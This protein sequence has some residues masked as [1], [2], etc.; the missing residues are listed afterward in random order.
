MESPRR[1]HV[2][3][4]RHVRKVPIASL[5]AA[6]C[7]MLLLRET[8]RTAPDLSELIDRLLEWRFLSSFADDGA[9][10]GTAFGISPRL[11]VC[12]TDI[13]IT[14]GVGGRFCVMR[15]RWH[16]PYHLTS[17]MCMSSGSA[18]SAR[19]CLAALRHALLHLAQACTIILGDMNFVSP[20]EGRLD[21]LTG[22]I[23]RSRSPEYEHFVNTFADCHEILA[24]CCRQP[25]TWGQIFIHDRLSVLEAFTTTAMHAVGRKVCRGALTPTRRNSAAWRADWHLASRSVYRRRDER[26][27][28]DALRR[29]PL[30]R[31]LSLDSDGFP[32]PKLPEKTFAV[33]I[34]GR[35]RESQDS[36]VAPGAPPARGM[37]TAVPAPSTMRRSRRTTATPRSTPLSRPPRSAL[38]PRLPRLPARCHAETSRFLPGR[39]R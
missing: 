21:V 39:P 14:P 18:F 4:V 6:G 12:H 10:G 28:R 36:H 29:K 9:S 22:G 32:L 13:S 16:T 26:R 37:R 33:G 30:F 17:P 27:L 15:P 11:H 31:S 35:P 7:D 34:R 2:A 3:A 20:V 23:R 1:R 19:G 5:P 8:R 38:G 25:D 24:G